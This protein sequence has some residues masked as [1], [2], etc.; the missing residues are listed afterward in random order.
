M[1]ERPVI[2]VKSE[3]TVADQGSKL[4][5]WDSSVRKYYTEFESSIGALSKSISLLYKNP[6]TSFRNPSHFQQRYYDLQTL[7]YRQQLGDIS[8]SEV[9][10][11]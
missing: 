2:V 5:R 8:A 3:S 1:S 9:S 10:D 11:A 6:V 4:Y 7:R